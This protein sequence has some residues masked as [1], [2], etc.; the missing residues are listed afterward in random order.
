MRRIEPQELYQEM[1]RGNVYLMDVRGEGAY[2][3]ALD[4]IPGD[5]HHSP[6]YA[7]RW[8]HRLPRDARIVTYCTCP[9][10]LTSAR[11]AAYLEKLGF[12]ADTLR[13]GLDAWKEAG[14]PV[15][16]FQ[17]EYMAQAA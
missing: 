2:R 4:H 12:H 16:R 5:V 13:G 17:D 3:R 15:S 10:E 6:G 11:V 14:L 8:I 9:G 1:R 7:H